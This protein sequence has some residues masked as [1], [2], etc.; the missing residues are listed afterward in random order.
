VLDGS[1][2]DSTFYPAVYG[3]ELGD[4]WN[5]PAVWKKCNPSIGVTIPLETVQAAYE[6][7]K[8]N[9][10]GVSP[11]SFV[12][13]STTRKSVPMQ[14]QHFG[15]GLHDVLIQ[16]GYS[17]QEAAK[18]SF[19]GWRHFFTSYMIKKLDKK[20]LKSQTGHKT[21]VML[22]HYSDHETEGDR[23]IIQITQKETFAGL[24]PESPKKLVFKNQCLAVAACQ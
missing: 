22:A 17:E 3:M 8:Q 12:F 18:Y 14:G 13:W 7:A 20:L 9:P 15:R 4:D 16:I 1:K 2:I 21:D 10:W 23:E 5:D 11:E 6:Q 19:H 24:L